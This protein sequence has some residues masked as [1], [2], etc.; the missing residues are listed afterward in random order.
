MSVVVEGGVT[1]FR[2]ETG[3]VRRI[4]KTITFEELTEADASQTITIG[5]PS[6]SRAAMV[7]GVAIELATVFT[8]GSSGTFTCDVGVADDIDKLVDGANLSSA[9]DNV[10]ASAPAGIAPNAIIAAGDTIRVTVDGSVNVD[11]AT[12]G[13]AT[14]TVLFTEVG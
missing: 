1:F 4:Y 8:D 9:V 3:P 6:M 12:A 2:Q 13:S 7:L 5:T 11:T 14:I 10:P